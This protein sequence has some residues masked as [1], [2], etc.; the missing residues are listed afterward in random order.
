MFD[1]EF[2][3]EFDCLLP[4]RWPVTGKR[5]RDASAARGERRLVAAVESRYGAEGL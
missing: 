3:W 1:W 2:D 4:S 5:V